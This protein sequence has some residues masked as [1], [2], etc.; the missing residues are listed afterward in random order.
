MVSNNY[1]PQQMLKKT[2]WLLLLIIWQMPASAQP[3]TPR[4]LYGDLFVEAQMRS[5]FPDGK[6]FVDCTP[7]Y[8]PAEIVKKYHAERKQPGFDL[9]QFVTDNFNL[10]VTHADNYQSDTSEGVKKH[11]AELWK[12]LRREPDE[13]VQNSS[14]LPLPY[15]YIVPGGRFREVYYWDSYFT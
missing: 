10:P 3:R 2:F 6:T 11:I 12:V 8:S 4:Q 1:K 13:P 9:K 14:L 7:K 5:V 15:P